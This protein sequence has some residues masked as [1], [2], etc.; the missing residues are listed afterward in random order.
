MLEA[1][2]IHVLTGTQAAR[3]S[4]VWLFKSWMHGV[5]RNTALGSVPGS[6]SSADYAEHASGSVPVVRGTAAAHGQQFTI[7]DY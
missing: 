5:I 1:S 4:L 2:E 7:H 6:G 3:A